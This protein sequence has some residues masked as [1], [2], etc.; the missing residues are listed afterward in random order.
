MGMVMVASGLLESITKVF[1]CIGY[2]SVMYRLSYTQVPIQ[3]REKRQDG[4]Q[5]TV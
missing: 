5:K 2:V 4:S 3:I 1:I